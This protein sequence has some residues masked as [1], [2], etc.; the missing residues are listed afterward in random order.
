MQTAMELLQGT[1]LLPGVGWLNSTAWSPFVIS[2]E[3]LN[4]L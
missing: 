3:L 4:K 1:E 2:A